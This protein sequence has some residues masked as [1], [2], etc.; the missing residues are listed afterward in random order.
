MV[1]N[2]PE[3]RIGVSQKLIRINSIKLK[4]ANASFYP[5][6][7]LGLFCQID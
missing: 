7:V 6:K 5:S 4:N 1:T 3:I 2:S